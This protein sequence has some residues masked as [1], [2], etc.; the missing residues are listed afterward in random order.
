[1]E[2]YFTVVTSSYLDGI[3]GSLQEEIPAV[4]SKYGQNQKLGKV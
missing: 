3:W 1:M 4:Y 2:R